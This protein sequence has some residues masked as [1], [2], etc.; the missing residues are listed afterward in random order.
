MLVSLLIASSQPVSFIAL[1]LWLMLCTF[2]LGMSPFS[3]LCFFSNDTLSCVHRATLYLTFI[4]SS[5]SGF[6][7][8]PYVSSSY[9]VELIP[10]SP[11]NTMSSSSL[12]LY[13]SVH[14]IAQFSHTLLLLSP[15]SIILVS[16]LFFSFS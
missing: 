2:S 14:I 5:L 11:Y 6:I 9:F 15:K 13:M 12:S 16:F 8:S 10:S 3:H 1:L 4:S 7:N